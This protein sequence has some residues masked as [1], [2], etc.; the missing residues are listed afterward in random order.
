M[1]LGFE[2]NDENQEA[3]P[4][5]PEKSHLSYHPPRLIALEDAQPETGATNVPEGSSGLLS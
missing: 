4:L 2:M 5:T 3:L 1:K